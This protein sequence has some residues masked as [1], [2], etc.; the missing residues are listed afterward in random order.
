M[1]TWKGGT[2]VKVILHL[3]HS[4]HTCSLKLLTKAA[5][6][7]LVFL[8]NEYLVS[9]SRQEFYSGCMEHYKALLPAVV[10]HY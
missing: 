7:I 2:S 10:R 4:N 3:Q 1:I 9:Q 6:K 5:S 8:K